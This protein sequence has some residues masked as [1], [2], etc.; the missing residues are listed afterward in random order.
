MNKILMVCLLW[1]LALHTS[2]QQKTIVSGKLLNCTDKVLEIVPSTGSFKDSVKVNADGTFYYSTTQIIAPFRA[3]LTNRKQ[4]QIQLFIA[5]GYDLQIHADVKDYASTRSSLVYQGLG[6]KTNGYWKGLLGN[7]KS[8]TTKWVKKNEN[9]YIAYLN[10]GKQAAA[11]DKVFTADNKEPSADYFRQSIQL[12]IHFGKFIAIYSSYAYENS[13]TWAQIQG[14]IAKLGYKSLLEEFKDERNLMSS[15]FSYLV[16]SYPFY[17]DNYNAFAADSLVKKEGNYSLYLAAKFY[18]GKVYDYYAYD[19]IPSKMTSLYKVEDFKRL[20]PFIERIDDPIVQKSVRALEATRLKAAMAL[21]AGAPSPLFN[22]A[23][24]SGKFYQ[25]AEMK[26]KVIYIDLWASWCG[27][28]KEETP[29]LKKIYD[30]LKNNDKV[31]I[32]SIASFDAKNRARRYEIIKK[33]Q[34]NWL[35]LEDTEDA[36]AKSYQANF[37]PRFIIIDKQGKIVDSDAV[38]PSEPEKLMAILNREISK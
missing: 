12:D 24:T 20:Q 32:I 19:H 17:C 34:M 4:I 8:D 25:L 5:P 22:L 18:S 23:D 26:G 13:Y 7:F 16:T 15:S 6:S 14:M 35:Q 21:Q 30:Q 9:D 27:P 11:M 3:N 31:Q 38:R 28:C 33:D 10:T 1:C 36:F 2:A 37:I 29:Y